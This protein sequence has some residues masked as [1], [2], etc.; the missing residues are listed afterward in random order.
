MQGEN[1]SLAAQLSE[2]TAFLST[3]PPTSEICADT[4]SLLFL[5]KAGILNA[6]VKHYDVFI[7]SVVLE[8]LALE[9]WEQY[10]ETIE[11]RN[12]FEKSILHLAP[13]HRTDMSL[14]SETELNRL[15]KGERAVLESWKNLGACF[16]LTDDKQLV[17]VCRKHSIPFTSAVI[18]P[19]MLYK[20]N[21]LTSGEMSRAVDAILQ[22][23]YFSRRIKS[24]VQNLLIFLSK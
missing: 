7:P 24:A 17:M 18:I 13:S 10:P 1:G 20:Y 3:F 14:F 8:E 15:D 23:G 16:I 6:V 12:L 4:S 21:V 19:A 2:L 11:I 9:K 22:M 5:A